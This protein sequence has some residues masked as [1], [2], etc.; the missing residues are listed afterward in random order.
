M[1]AIIFIGST[2]LG[3]ASHQSRFLIPLLQ[4]LGLGEAAIRGVILT[5]RKCAHLTEYALLAVLL[6]R[7]LWRRPVLTPRAPWRLRDAVLPFGICVLYATLD[8]IHQAFV[9]S[10]TGSPVDVMIDAGGAAIGLALL[11]LWHRSRPARST[12]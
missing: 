7:G 1:M 2:D 4:W 10:R 3:A 12:I 9:P 5:L 8:E 11:W 6:W